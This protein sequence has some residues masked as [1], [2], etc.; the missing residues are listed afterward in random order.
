[1]ASSRH[2]RAAMYSP[3][4]FRQVYRPWPII[5]SA[6]LL[7]VHSNSRAQLVVETTL[8]STALQRLSAADSA[9]LSDSG[10][11]SGSDDLAWFAAGLP[12]LLLLVHHG[13]PPAL[14]VSIIETPPLPIVPGGS[15]S[16][17]STGS[18]G[19]GG[20]SPDAGSEPVPAN[21]SQSV[22]EP[23]LLALAAAPAAA[24]ALMLCRRTRQRR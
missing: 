19:T 5:V 8:H 2:R 11:S 15:G 13:S 22:P 21:G 18:G 10:D 20:K 14:P 7:L 24:F 12:L 16:G 1:M 4:R 23:G 3:S 6:A 9:E 17:A